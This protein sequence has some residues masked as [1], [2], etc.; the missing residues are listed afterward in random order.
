LILVIRVIRK[1]SKGGRP[2]TELLGAQVGFTGWVH[3]LLAGF[4][5]F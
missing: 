5:L 3:R 2:N 1:V 4:L